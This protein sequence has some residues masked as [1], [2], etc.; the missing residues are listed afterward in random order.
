V[1]KLNTGIDG[2]MHP[3]FA[4][5]V[6]NGATGLSEAGG[7]YPVSSFTAAPGTIPPTVNPPH[8]PEQQQQVSD[9]YAGATG[10]PVVTAPVAQPATSTR[11]AAVSSNDSGSGGFF[12]DLARK[13][14]LSGGS[15]TTATTTPAPAPKPVARPAAAKPPAVVT[16]GAAKP[17]GLNDLRLGESRPVPPKSIANAQA[18]GQSPVVAAQS[19]ASSQRK[20]SDTQT[21]TQATAPSGAA[22]Q[23]MAGV[24]PV[25]PA[26]SFDNRWGGSSFR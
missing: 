23:A 25:V 17:P 14:G 21:T 18:Q 12:G 20:P 2:G 4:A 22:G 16:A 1:A 13:V 26:N 19:P 10:T 15:E 6:P 5:R 11:V 3:V 7:T 24:Q 9:P 8:V